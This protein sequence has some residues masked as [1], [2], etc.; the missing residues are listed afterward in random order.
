MFAKQREKSFMLL[1]LEALDRRLP[2]NHARYA[3]F[4]EMLRASK[5]WL[6]RRTAR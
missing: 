6:C 3:Y 1:V 5:G 2:K 4:Q